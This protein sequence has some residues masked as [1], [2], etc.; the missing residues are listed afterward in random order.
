MRI[1]RR[2]ATTTYP[3][4]ALNLAFLAMACVVA[5]LVLGTGRGLDVTAAVAPAPGG[6]AAGDR[7][8]VVRVGAD[9][10]LEVDGRR[11]PPDRLAGYLK[12]RTDAGTVPPVISR[13]V[14]VRPD[15]RAPYQ[16]VMDA[17][18]Q[19]RQ[20][21]RTLRLG[22]EPSVVLDVDGAGGGDGVARR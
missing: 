8:I 9:G 4:A 12:T 18:D 3:V 15:S 5:S 7:E 20:V 16:A 21:R 11:L 1:A 19:L 22:R 10:A 2:P 17:L 6:A 14:V 13:R